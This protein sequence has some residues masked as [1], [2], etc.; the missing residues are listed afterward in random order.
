MSLVNCI[1]IVTVLG[2]SFQK[3]IEA[4]ALSLLGA[5]LLGLGIILS[6]VLLSGDDESPQHPTPHFTA[7]V[8]QVLF[9]I[10]VTCTLVFKMVRSGAMANDSIALM[11]ARLVDRTVAIAHEASR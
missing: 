10:V 9:C 3:R 7:F 1:S 11:A 8:C 6:R 2:G 4:Y 5:S